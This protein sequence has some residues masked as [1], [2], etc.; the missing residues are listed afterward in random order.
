ME[1][2]VVYLD[3]LGFSRQIE[4]KTQ[5]INLS[6]SEVRNMWQNKVEDLLKK[7]I[8]NNIVTRT[9]RDT[10]DSWLILLKGSMN[11]YPLLDSL[12][13]INNLPIEV[14]VGFDNFPENDSAFLSDTMMKFLKDN[15]LKDY[16]EWF[17]EKN[18]DSIKNTF[19]L[20]F[21]KAYT[22]LGRNEY[23]EKPY[24]QAQYYL[25][26]YHPTFSEKNKTDDFFR[27]Q[28]C[29]YLINQI[30]QISKFLDDQ[31]G[32][33]NYYV[34]PVILYNRKPIYDKNKDEI[35]KLEEKKFVICSNSGHGKTIFLQK[36]FI[37]KAKCF[38]DRTQQILP[39]YFHLSKLIDLTRDKIVDFLINKIFGNREQVNGI[40]RKDLFDLMDSK[41]NI[42]EI[43]FLLDGFDQ[44]QQNG[45]LPN[46]LG[47]GHGDD[48]FK[49]SK[50][51][52]ASRPHAAMDLFRYKK[53]EITP[54]NSQQITLY[55]K[56]LVGIDHLKLKKLLHDFFK[57]AEVPIL[58]FLLGKIAQEE[59]LEEISQESDIYMSDVYRV[60]YQIIRKDGLEKFKN[61][62]S[63]YQEKCSIPPA[64]EM[65]KQ[66]QKIA[67]IGLIEKEKL[68]I[69]KCVLKE[70]VIPMLPHIHIDK[71]NNM[72]IEG[73]SDVTDYVMK[74]LCEFG[75]ICNILDEGS[76]AT[77]PLYIE[78]R[79]Q[80]FQAYFAA[81]QLAEELKEGTINLVNFIKGKTDEAWLEVYR[82][83]TELSEVDDS[84]KLLIAENMLT[85]YKEQ[86]NKEML[87][88]AAKVF[89][90]LK[91][92]D[93]KLRKRIKYELVGLVELKIGE[94]VENEQL[95]RALRDIEE[96]DYITRYATKQKTFNTVN[97]FYAYKY[98][99]STIVVG[100]GSIN[101][102]D[103]MF[104]EG[105]KSESTAKCDV[106]FA[107]NRI[108]TD[109]A[110]TILIDFSEKVI[111]TVL[112]KTDKK[113]KEL[114]K[115]FSEKWI[116]NSITKTKRAVF[117]FHGNSIYSFRKKLNPIKL[118]LVTKYES[119]LFDH[120]YKN[121]DDKWI[122]YED[123]CML[124]LGETYNEAL[125]SK[126][127]DDFLVLDKIDENDETLYKQAMAACALANC[128][129]A[130]QSKNQEMIEKI[131]SYCINTFKNGENNVYRYYI[132][133]ALAM[134]GNQSVV[135]YFL[136]FIKKPEEKQRWYAAMVLGCLN[137]QH[138]LIQLDKLS[139]EGE[140]K[141]SNK[142]ND[143][144][145]SFANQALLINSQ[146]YI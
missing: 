83:F 64:D 28:C 23:W 17:K 73:V 6:S 127:Y 144:I 20:I 99:L 139:K 130:K 63:Q 56:N 96:I 61:K 40:G 111:A 68:S 121:K 12:N 15:I 119:Y 117:F 141:F 82:F 91:I 21:D 90:G 58:M 29:N 105:L 25:L 143:K 71:V 13:K 81:C 98:A 67:Y 54:F 120:I 70:K 74:I 48:D 19:I 33:R 11:V 27:K 36:Y 38:I 72:R 87:Y 22:A 110:K 94:V 116:R 112:P 26:R 132:A 49:R 16:R 142:E 50:V 66:L 57:I 122:K 5:G 65:M 69:S 75:I 134:I 138:M 84:N 145:K 8:E 37:N 55:F 24:Q 3:I 85:W 31:M 101:F 9:K 140:K 104:K 77:N 51:I 32:S 14:A 107:L 34:D 42:G 135:N 76:C 125:V 45:Y 1:Q 2:F 80:S 41:F 97:R 60:F 4:E 137:D 123:I 53:L 100:Q 79:H 62:Y 146:T 88:N 114:A 128:F 89:S 44:T 35:L 136:S 93:S 43:L 78:F 86:D 102:S 108:G 18:T 109:I 52:I 92:K 126:F 59:G 106:I 124:I 10:H 103:E 115:L 95:F 7:H 30:E 131:T 133:G 39:F 47:L 129:S 113:L 46:L 118:K